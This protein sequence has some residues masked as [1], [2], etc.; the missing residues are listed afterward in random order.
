MKYIKTCVISNVLKMLGVE[1]RDIYFILKTFTTWRI[2]LLIVQYFAFRY[3]PHQENFLGGGM[4]RYVSNPYFW[5]YLN[6][7]GEHYLSIAV[8]GYKNLQYFFFP[9]FPMTVRFVARLFGGSIFV[10]ALVGQFVSNLGLLMALLGMYKLME[11]KTKIARNTILLLL[12]FPTS[13][14][15]VSFYTESLFLALCVWSFYFAKE[16]KWFFAFLLAG[17]CTATRVVGIALVA[18]IATEYFVKNNIVRLPFKDISFKAGKLFLY[19]LVGLS[20]ILGYMYFLK[21]KVG[22][23]LEFFHSV[24]IYGEQRS[25][26]FVLLPQ[27]FYRYVFKVLPH[28]NYS[29]LSVVFTTW[30]EFIV[31]AM[32]GLALGLSTLAN[33]G[34][35]RLQK[36]FIKWSYL[37]FSVFT[38]LI[39]TLSGSFSSL[40]RY[41]LIIFPI[42]ILFS[43]LSLKFNRKVNIII[44]TFLTIALTLFFSLFVRGYWVS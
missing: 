40:P 43:K 29:Y 6:F 23:P 44:Y 14:Y 7:D 15:L 12:L 18:G 9:L 17:L 28:I 25:P 3:I 20:G 37:T 19:T 41:V 33:L 30:L 34:V 42:F 27:V 16:R 10:Y 31:A 2:V 13:F 11:R 39:P 1:K 35:K 36:F 26:G 21:V 8:N 22:D 5:S 4:E 32:F 24:G 38:Y